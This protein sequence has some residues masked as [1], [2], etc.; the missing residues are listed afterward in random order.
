MKVNAMKEAKRGEHSDLVGLSASVEEMR[1]F[2]SM[3]Y[4][5]SARFVSLSPDKIER[6][7]E[8]GLKLIV[9]FLAIDRADMWELDKDKHKHVESGLGTFVQKVIDN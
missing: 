4:N 5:I 9:Q 6:E 2:K 1:Q 7:I 8:E 3:L